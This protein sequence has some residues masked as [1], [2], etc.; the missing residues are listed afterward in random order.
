MMFS[1]ATREAARSGRTAVLSV[2]AARTRG[3]AKVDGTLIEAVPGQEAAALRDLDAD[4]LA[5]LSQPGSVILVGERAAGSAGAL[6]AAVDAREFPAHYHEL[7]NE[8]DRAPV[9]E[10]LQSW[11]D[12]RFP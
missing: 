5:L 12:A 2:G 10:A 11:L 8:R 7:F 1:S 3:L 9:F 4:V 6:S